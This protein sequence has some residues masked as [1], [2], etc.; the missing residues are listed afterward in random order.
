MLLRDDIFLTNL[1]C[2]LISSEELALP[3]LAHC[4]L[5][6][7]RCHDHS[8]LLSSYLC[9]KKR[10]ENSS[11]SACGLHL[12]DLTYFRLDCSAKQP[13]PIQALTINLHEDLGY[14]T[15]FSS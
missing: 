8:L 7:L 1:F 12:Q 14:F 11:C 5:F 9:R 6:R 13:K 3:H 15:V 2:Q 4:E 10:K